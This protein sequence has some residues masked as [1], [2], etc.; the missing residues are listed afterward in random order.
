VRRLHEHAALH[1]TTGL[2]MSAWVKPTG[3]NSTIWNRTL[4][5]A[6]IAQLHA[7]G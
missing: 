7:N 1:G 6:E 5:D 3:D 2:T 4:S